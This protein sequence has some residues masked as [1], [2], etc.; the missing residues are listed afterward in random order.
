VKSKHVLL[1]HGSGGLSSQELITG[2]FLPL[3]DNPVLF[4]LE[5]SAV[6]QA[7]GCRLAFTTDSYV[8]DPIFF[9]GGDIGTLAVNGT[10]NDLSMRG[11]EPLCLSAGLILEEGF[12]MADLERVMG[13][14]GEASRAAGVP[15]VTGDTKVVPR[16]KADKVFINTSGIGVVASGIEIS[17]AKAR[18]G[19]L[20]LVSGT[21]ADHGVTI[22]TRRAGLSLDGGLASDTM[23]LHR[24]V[25]AMIEA[26]GPAIHSLRD[27]TRGGI[28]TS[29]AEMARKAGVCIEIEESSVPVRPEVGAAC[30]ILGLDPFYLANEGKCLALVAPEKAPEILEAMRRRPEGRDAAVIGRVTDRPAGRVILKTAVGG[31]RLMEP[32]SGEPLPRIC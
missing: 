32:L 18:P 16:G 24:L 30:E 27:P 2:V 22:L 7:R 4:D 10:I 25:Q 5:D 26:G 8:V 9:P 13:A 6:V 14:L 19:D 31:S 28:A 12:P 3:L 29:L 17:S 1:D 21:M 15:V 23:A 20:V 11:A